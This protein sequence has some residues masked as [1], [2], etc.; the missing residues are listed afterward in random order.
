MRVLQCITAAAL[1]AA[2]GAQAQPSAGIAP[3]LQK[4]CDALPAAPTTNRELA[5]KSQCVLVGAVPSASRYIEARELARQSMALGDPAGGFL[6]YVA[7]ASDP[8]N[9]YLRDGKVDMETYRRLGARSLEQ[10]RDQI[11]ALDGLAFA[12]AK[13]HVNAAVTLATY[14]Y[15][16]AAPQNVTRVRGITALLLRSGE[17]TPVVER[18]ASQ[19][20]AVAQ[21]APDTKASLKA[22]LDAVQAAAGAAGVAYLQMNDGKT[23]ARPTLKSVSSGE[24][25]SAEYLP[26]TQRSVQNTYLVKGEWTERWTFATCEQEIPVNVTFRADGWGGASYAASPEIAPPGGK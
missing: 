23:C 8:D 24:L 25:K 20:A 13:G 14:F 12:A 11:E 16:T 3:A 15:E 9:T 1:L 18:L 7:F 26:L 22:F 2:A 19:A 4:E 17:R 10:R 6:L 5:A 21:I